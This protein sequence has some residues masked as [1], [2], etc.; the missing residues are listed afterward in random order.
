MKKQK[1]IKTD[2]KKL[3]Q[4]LDKDIDYSD[5][6]ATTKTKEFWEDAVIVIPAKKKHSKSKA[7][8]LGKFGRHGSRGQTAG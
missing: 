3:K 4:M 7:S 8:D 6:P 1:S 2:F 5:S